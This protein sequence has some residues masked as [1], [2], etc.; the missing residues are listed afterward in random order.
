MLKV[1]KRYLKFL[2]EINY[3]EGYFLYLFIEYVDIIIIMLI[4]K[5]K[6]YFTIFIK[7]LIVSTLAFSVKLI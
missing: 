4:I 7:R 6:I 2:Q 5:H 1:Q 3:R